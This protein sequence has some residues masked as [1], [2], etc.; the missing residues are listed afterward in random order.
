MAPVRGARVSR[1][2]SPRSARSA[3]SLPLAHHVALFAA[4]AAVALVEGA[5]GPVR[6]ILVLF[7]VHAAAHARAVRA[8]GVDRRAAARAAAPRARARGGRARAVRGAARGVAR[9]PALRDAVRPRAHRE[10][11]RGARVRA[12]ALAAL[13][14][15]AAVAAHAPTRRRSRAPRRASRARATTRCASRTSATRTCT[16]RSRSTRGARARSPARATP[17]ASRAARRSACSPTTPTGRPRR[18]VQLRRAARLRGRHRPQRPARRDPDLPEPRAARLRLARVPRGAALAEA[19][20]HA[21]ERLRLQQRA[22]RRVIRSAART[23]PT[24]AKPARGPWREIQDAAEAYYDRSAACRFTTFV[25]YEWTGMPAGDNLHR[26]VIFRNAVAQAYP[27][28]YIETPT[29]EGLWRAL[30]SECLGAGNGCDVLAIPHNSNLSNGRMFTATRSRRR[31]DHGRRRARRARGSSRSSRSRSTRATAS[32]ARAREDELCSFEKLADGAHDG[33]CARTAAPAAA[34]A[35]LR[36]RGAARRARA[37]A[38]RLGVN[39]FKFGLIGTTDTH[40]AAPGMVD[41][42][43]FRGHAAGTVNVRWGVPA[44]SRPP[45]LQPGR[46]RRAVGRG[47]LARRAVRGDAPP[48]GL[49]HE[50]PAHRG[51]LLRRLGLSR[52]PLRERAAFAAQGYAGGVPMGGDLPPSANAAASAALRGVGAARP[53][54]RRDRARRSQR[55]QIVKGWVE[56]G[57]SRERV[58]DVAGDARARAGRRPRHAA[59]PRPAPISSAASGAIPSSIPPR[60]RSTTRAWSRTRAAAGTPMRATRAASTAAIPKPSRASSPRAATPRCRSRSRSAPG[61]RRSGTRRTASERAVG[62]QEDPPWRSSTFSAAAI[63]HPG[64]RARSRLRAA[65]RRGQADPTRGLPRQEGG[66][67]LLLSEGRHAR[68]HR[69]GVRFRDSYEDFQDAGAE[70]IGVSS[71]CARRTRSSPSK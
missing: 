3:A 49:R 60:P 8:R 39:P 20:L 6:M 51:A 62:R 12:A 28:T 47:E 31:A 50:R 64:G 18:A 2:R 42:D 67:A 48:R 9:V 46:A 16:R 33:H 43:Q 56:G 35:T 36:A 65:R 38:Q 10:P 58:Y 55:I 7:A 4:T 17:T 29:P 68:L 61:R 24:A 11:A 45:R 34:A 30:E 14:A 22:S 63:R 19:R 70:V 40:L 66:R 23:A 25:G 53:G 57:E 69:G 37:R 5:A 59:R 26:N 1:C 41:E 27:T 44:V 21:R 15:L 13:L 52:R 54:R 71:D 32:A